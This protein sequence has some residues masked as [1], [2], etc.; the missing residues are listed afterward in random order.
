MDC[1]VDRC[2]RNTCTHTP[3]DDL[4]PGSADICRPYSCSATLDCR[5]HYIGS[6]KVLI[7]GEILDGSFE[8]GVQTGWR[9][10]PERR[11][12]VFVQTADSSGGGTKPHHGSWFA[13]LGGL[14]LDT[15]SIT[16]RFDLPAGSTHLQLIVDTNFQTESTE[17]NLDTLVV[18][19][20]DA[21]GAVLTRLASFSN[22]DAAVKANEWT[23]G[24]IQAQVDVTKWAGMKGAGLRFTSTTD[25]SVL[26]DFM[27]DNVRLSVEIC[28]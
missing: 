18:E 20:L 10:E 9:Q 19:L 5:T 6:T 1:T 2:N 28:Q 13:W 4:C 17:Q 21:Q 3:D 27:L 15:M 7:D 11:Q 26:S 14:A 22:Q 24:G 23:A 25:R 16:E 12:P 8:F